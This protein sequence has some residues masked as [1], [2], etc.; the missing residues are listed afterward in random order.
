MAER[1]KQSERFG[2]YLRAKRLAVGL[3]QDAAAVALGYNERYFLSRIE[4]DRV[5][6]PFEK[7]PVIAQL[8]GIAIEELV[9]AVVRE[10]SRLVRA[11]VDAIVKNAATMQPAS[12]AKKA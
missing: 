1:K 11:K 3:S 4:N 12:F 8:Y 6:L 10:Q 2:D 9:E 5:A 7:I